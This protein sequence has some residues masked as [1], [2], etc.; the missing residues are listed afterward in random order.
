MNRSRSAFQCLLSGKGHVPR[1][2]NGP[3]RSLSGTESIAQPVQPTVVA[4]RRETSLSDTLSAIDI[5]RLPYVRDSTP[6]GK[7]SRSSAT[8]RNHRLSRTNTKQPH[9]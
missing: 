9:S 3:L 8:D 5:A 1:A 2:K 6:A 7:A 4:R